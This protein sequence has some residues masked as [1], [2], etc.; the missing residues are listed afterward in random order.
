MHNIMMGMLIGKQKPVL[1]Q[2]SEVLFSP[3]V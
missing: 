3:R 1:Q 2:E